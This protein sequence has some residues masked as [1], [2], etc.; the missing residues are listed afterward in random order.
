MRRHRALLLPLASALLLACGIESPLLTTGDLTTTDA[1]TST[2]AATLS[3]SET[4][5]SASTTSED[6][7]TGPTTGEPVSPGCGEGVLE[8][9]HTE[10]GGLRTTTAAYGVAVDGAGRIVV[11]AEVSGEATVLALDPAG[12]EVWRTK[13]SGVMSDLA[14]I[15]VDESGQILVGGTEWLMGPSAAS[16]RALSPDGEELWS[17]SEPG[18]EPDNF[19]TIDGL[20]LGQG[21]LFSAGTSNHQLVVRRHDLAT[22]EAVW[23]TTYG[24]EIVELYAPEVA[25]VGDKVLAVARAV[26]APGNTAHPFVLQLDGDGV[27]ESFTVEDTIAGFW[28]DVEPIGAAGERVLVGEHLTDDATEGA[29]VRR[30]GPG[31]A[32]VWSTLFAD[33]AVGESIDDVKVDA[34][35]RILVVGWTTTEDL[36]RR[37]P[38]IRCITGDG[39]EVWQAPFEF[40]DSE[41]HE[42]AYGGAFGPGF[43]VAVGGKS[44]GDSFEMWVRKYSLD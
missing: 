23:T 11:L 12:T 28:L 16:L 30:A 8:W 17:F 5:T 4:S 22:G 37:V 43:M 9:H 41:D 24:E 33:S 10:S 2:T 40:D 31:G 38:S 27:V 26:L 35:E 1:D 20:G 36:S 29:S 6:P 34:H 44:T 3:D 32:E 21:A 25:V 19:A 7:T 13:L 39:S 42:L 14:D 15:V 18:A